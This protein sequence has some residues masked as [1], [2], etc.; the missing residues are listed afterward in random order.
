MEEASNES[1]LLPAKK[2]RPKGQCPE[3][4]TEHRLE[5]YASIGLPDCRAISES[6]PG[7]YRRAILQHSNTPLLHLSILAITYASFA[8]NVLYPFLQYLQVL[9]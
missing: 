7:S 3:G 9:R 5:A 6:H 2:R 1:F 8:G 4:A